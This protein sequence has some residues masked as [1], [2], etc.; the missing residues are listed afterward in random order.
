MTPTPDAVKAEIETG[1]YA[2]LLAPAW[3][4][5]YP[6]PDPDPVEPPADDREAHGKW[7]ETCRSNR[8]KAE[9]AHLLSPDAIFDLVRILRPRFEALGWTGLEE[10]LLQ[11]AREIR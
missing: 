6:A 4:G 7:R 8:V 1:P 10:G 3:V 11:R 9:R 2:A 5:Y